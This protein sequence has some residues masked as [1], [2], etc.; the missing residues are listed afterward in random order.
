MGAEC[1][2]QEVPSKDGEAEDPKDTVFTLV[3]GDATDLSQQANQ[4]GSP[5]KAAKA[6]STGNAFR[7][8]LLREAEEKEIL[9][10]EEK[11][12]EIARY[13]AE[14]E[15]A[16]EDIVGMTPDEVWEDLDYYELELEI[17]ANPKPTKGWGGTKRPASGDQYGVQETALKPQ[18]KAKPKKLSRDELEVK[19]RRERLKKKLDG[20]KAKREAEE[21]DWED[22]KEKYRE[23][24]RNFLN[25]TGE[26]APSK[27]EC[28]KKEAAML[29]FTMPSNADRENTRLLMME[30]FRKQYARIKAN[31]DKYGEVPCPGDNNNALAGLAGNGYNAYDNYTSYEI[32]G[33]SLG[34]GAHQ[35]MPKPE[36]VDLPPDFMKPVGTLTLDELNKYDCKN[37]RLLVSIYGD[38]FDVSD[39]PDKY[40]EDG[41]YWFMSGHDLT[42][43]F[44]AG[45]DS[46]DMVDKCFDYWKVAPET[47]RDSK[48]RLIYGWVAW[49]E[50]EYRDPVGKLEPYLKE[51]GL[52]GPPMEESEDCSIM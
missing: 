32:K 40:D 9:E 22:N 3:G 26:F 30:P 1:Q 28:K 38:I 34:E 48:L 35:P 12:A 49:Y 37:K 11:E 46:P 51:G 18:K 5:P 47:L 24:A 16:G 17:Q 10:R 21:R 29:A 52:K 4:A 6:A 41:P 25:Q 20:M 23:K 19:Q 33:L 31:R 36:K 44:A 43:G 45:K 27:A 42:W 39:R 50:F 13:F 14:K 8:R 15:A 2:K 7:D